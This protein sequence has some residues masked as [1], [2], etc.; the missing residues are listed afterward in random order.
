MAIFHPNPAITIIK[1][2]LFGH[3]EHPEDAWQ[4][5][6]K[7]RD[8]FVSLAMTIFIAGFGFCIISLTGCA[9]VISEEMRAKIDKEF[10][11]ADLFKDPDAHKGKLVMLGG[12]IISAKNTEEGVYLEV[13]QT[14]LD[15]R[16]IPRDIDSSYGR[17][18]VFFEGYLDTAVYSRGR[19]ITVAGEVIGKKIRPLDE[20]EYT[21]PLLKSREL[22]LLRPGLS[23]PIGIGIGIVGTF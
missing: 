22:H 17:F 4:S 3:C 5:H 7:R 16:G 1:T 2:Y 12:V 9:H 14:P 11:A 6:Y 20:I 8:C 19:K 18:I 21:Y 13:L 10:Y 23:I 15:F